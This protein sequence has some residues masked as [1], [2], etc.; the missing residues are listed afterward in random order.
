MRHALAFTALLVLSACGMPRED[1]HGRVDD[2]FLSSY[3]QLRAD[4]V[5]EGSVHARPGAGWHGPETL[6]GHRWRWTAGRAE[7]RV[8]NDS[9]GEIR[10]SFRAQAHP[11]EG[12]RAL[13][14]TLGE[15]LLW[16]GPL[17]V[18]GATEVRFG[19]ALPPGESILVFST[20]LP[21]QRK[22]TDPRA[23]AFRLSDVELLATP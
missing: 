6:E 1:T 2:G 12:E 16:G 13:R 5:L 23:L 3:A 4:P 14:V 7:L 9:A 15:R 20:D 8:R 10:L 21:A 17:A 19:T 11:V 18:R 22:G